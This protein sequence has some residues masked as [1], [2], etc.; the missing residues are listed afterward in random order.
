[1]SSKIP[2]PGTVLGGKY[3]VV[4]LLGEGGMGVVLEAENEITGKRV[5]VKWL[6]PELGEHPEGGQRLIREAQASS[7]VRHPNVVDVYDIAKDGDSM[8]IVM[9]FLE[10]ETL[11]ALLQ[12]GNVPMYELIAMIIPAMRGVHAA[13]KVGIIHRDIKPA[14]IFLTNEDDMPRPV[15]K[16][17]DFGISKI[18]DPKSLSLTKTGAAM[19]TPMY[20]SYEQLTGVKDLDHRTDVYAFGVILYEAITG[21]APFQAETFP[22]LAIQI[23]TQEPTPPRQVRDGIPP[24]L[25]KLV[26]KAMAKQRDARIPNLQ[27]FIDEL[28]PFSTERGFRE[29]MTDGAAPVPLVPVATNPE[30]ETPIANAP[31]RQ[32]ERNKLER[33]SMGRVSMQVAPTMPGSSSDQGGQ[34]TKLLIAAAAAVVIGLGAWIA[35]SGP[36]DPPPVA[37]APPSL[38]STPNPTANQQ[39]L[40]AQPKAQVAAPEPKLDTTALAPEPTPAPVTAADVQT[41]QLG[42]TGAAAPHAVDAASEKRRE[43]K[44]RKDAEA[45]AAPAVAAP[46][47]A[48]AA[49]P[50][51]SGRAGV[52]CSSDFK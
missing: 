50:C 7:K 31:S 2:S 1:M 19:G 41:A 10:G 18:S 30:A 45:A 23:A 8:F 27:A 21:Q 46:A 29:R 28:E 39:P 47:A 35:L 37:A 52:V 48:P 20:M 43:R 17:L 33:D 24:S 51:G 49:S 42:K 6:H 22:Q 14:N 9:E 15:P 11:E 26:Q 40:S 34:R 3:R 44:A 38:P 12:R 4:R 5:A 36:S 16:V 13:H 25:E 32:T